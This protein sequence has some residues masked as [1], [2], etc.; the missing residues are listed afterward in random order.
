MLAVFGAAEVG[1][2]DEVNA[3]L[4]AVHEL[5]AALVCCSEE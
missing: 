1:D 4:G 2:G 3:D 5:C